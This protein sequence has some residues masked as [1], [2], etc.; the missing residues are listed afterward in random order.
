MDLERHSSA[1]AA[2][3]MQARMRRNKRNLGQYMAELLHQ[4]RCDAAVDIGRDGKEA[5]LM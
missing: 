2:R 1:V 3:T 4:R 5:L